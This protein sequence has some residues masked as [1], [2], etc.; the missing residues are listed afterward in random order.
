[1]PPLCDPT[2]PKLQIRGKAYP[3]IRELSVARALGDRATVGSICAARAAATD[4]AYAYRP[5]IRALGD[6]M[7]KSLV[8]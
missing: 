7:A 8:P 3:A 5:A 6:R 1:L 2:S 4:A